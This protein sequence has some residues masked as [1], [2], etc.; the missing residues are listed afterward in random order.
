MAQAFRLS[1]YDLRMS[2]IRAVG[3]DPSDDR[4]VMLA[5]SRDVDTAELWR[6]ALDAADI[7]SEIRIEDAV[8]TGRSTLTT[9][10]NGPNSYQLFSFALWIP[11]GDREAA[12]ATLIDGGWD[13]RYG[14]RTE[15]I[16]AGLALRGALV[17]IGIAI[18]VVVIQVLRG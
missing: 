9:H 3:L 15:T 10:A 13:G 11:A 2:E 12:A 1:C 14:Q 18:G 6:D 7:E 8:L 5:V 4:W 16:P 17:M